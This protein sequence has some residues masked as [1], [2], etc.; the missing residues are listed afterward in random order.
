MS[1]TMIVFVRSSNVT[2]P[3]SLSSLP[4]STRRR[5][6][7]RSSPSRSG[8]A[9]A[10]AR[11]GVS[12]ARALALLFEAETVEMRTTFPGASSR[13]G[14]ERTRVERLVHGTSTSGASLPFTS[15]G[16][17]DVRWLTS[18][19]TRTRSGYVLES[20]EMRSPLK[21]TGRHRRLRCAPERGAARHGALAARRRLRL[22]SAGGAGASAAA[23]ARPGHGAGAAS[24]R[25]GWRSAASTRA[26]RRAPR[27]R[28]ARWRAHA[29][30]SPRQWWTA[31]V[32]SSAISVSPSVRT[33]CDAV[34]ASRA[35]PQR[36]SCAATRARERGRH[37]WE[38]GSRAR[39]PGT[40]PV[41]VVTRR[42]GLLSRNSCSRRVLG[43]A[44]FTRRPRLRLDVDVANAT[45]GARCSLR[46]RRRLGASP[47][48]M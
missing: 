11:R 7:G 30:S 25:C 23:G 34:P 36:P 22:G 48:G 44:L 38:S 33:T 21:D 19:S 18:A 27:T 10:R 29:A 28:P 17:D 47:A 4:F 9:A 14:F 1:R 31:G 45:H 46:S 24:T 15:S 8:R 37:R 16:G 6:R 40:R 43:H 5:R 12:A 20:S 3:R 32:A 13:V 42:G 39:R 2:L 41:E 35:R 26:R